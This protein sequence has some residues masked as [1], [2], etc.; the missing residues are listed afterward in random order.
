MLVLAETAARHATARA[1]EGADHA[2]VVL[3]YYLLRNAVWSYFRE[4]AASGPDE[5][6][7]IMLVDLAISV[8]TRA[9]LLGYHRRELERQHR[10][11]GALKR[12]VDEAPPV[13]GVDARE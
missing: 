10:W 8:A 11:G 1:G 12:L 13:W 5:E 6:R 3:E 9:A 4:K 7:A 2:R